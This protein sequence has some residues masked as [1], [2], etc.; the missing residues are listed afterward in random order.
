MNTPWLDY[1]LLIFIVTY[2]LI[3]ALYHN[4]RTGKNL[5]TVHLGLNNKNQHYERT[6]NIMKS[7]KVSSSSSLSSEKNS[8]VQGSGP[9]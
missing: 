7:S 1:L 8:K 5:S 4:C 3:K 2:P 9:F 6:I